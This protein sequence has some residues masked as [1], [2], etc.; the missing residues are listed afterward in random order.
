MRYG[1]WKGV[2][3]EAT[4]VYLATQLESIIVIYGKLELNGLDWCT[5]ARPVRSPRAVT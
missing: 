5:I 2:D 1:R 4:D 3:G